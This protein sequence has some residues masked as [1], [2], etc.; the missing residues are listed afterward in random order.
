MF[1]QPLLIKED[2]DLYDLDS[3][4][5]PTL[6]GGPCLARPVLGLLRW[7]IIRLKK[8]ERPQDA[9]GREG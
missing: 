6:Q 4:P 8:G 7:V 3:Y 1:S 2:S 5:P 9:C